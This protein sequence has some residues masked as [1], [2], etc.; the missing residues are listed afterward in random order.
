MSLAGLPPATLALVVAGAVLVYAGNL[1]KPFFRTRWRTRLRN[2]PGP[3][4]QSWFSGNLTKNYVSN[5]AGAVTR[6]R[7]GDY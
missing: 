1:V 2:L 6:H 4:S 7:R 3:K 5:N